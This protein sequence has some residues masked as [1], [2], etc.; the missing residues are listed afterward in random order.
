[1][2]SDPT[3]GSE[4][5]TTQEAADMLG[6]VQKT[7][8]AW[9]NLGYIKPIEGNPVKRKQ[10]RYYRRRDIERLIQQRMMETTQQRAS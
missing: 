9:R 1:M 2:R 8:Y 3:R 10:P 4:L 6:I 7:L 5:L